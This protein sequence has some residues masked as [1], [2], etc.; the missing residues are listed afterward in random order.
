MAIKIPEARLPALRLLAGLSEQRLQAL[1]AAFEAATP[2]LYGFDLAPEVAKRSGLDVPEAEQVITALTSMYFHLGHEEATPEE[3]AAEVCA[4]LATL[5]NRPSAEHMKRL[6]RILPR[7]LSIEP[8]AI[9]AKA[10]N[11]AQESAYTYCE[12]RVVSDMRPVFRSDVRLE[13]AGVV[14]VHNL[15]IL[16]HQG[17]E[18]REFFVTLDRDDL[19]RLREVLERAALKEGTLRRFL[20]KTTARQLDAIKHGKE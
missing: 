10:L 5:E 3:F 17:P 19:A 6:E 12:A 4:G 7:L 18:M 11:V 15:K 14:I 8:L 9:T 2:A 13:P 20:A 16:F 1:I